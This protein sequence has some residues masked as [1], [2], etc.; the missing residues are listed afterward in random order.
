MIFFPA[1]FRK[2]LGVLALVFF[3]GQAWADPDAATILEAARSNLLGQKAVLNATLRTD[4]TAATPP[5]TTPLQIR[6]D[7]D[8]HYIFDNPP[9]ELI[10]ELDQ[11]SSAISERLGGKTAPVKPARFDEPVRDTA[12]TYED[13]ALKFLYWKNPILR[14]EDTALTRKCW[15]IEIQAPR[16]GQSQYGVARLWIDQESGALM[17]M[18]GYDMQGKLVRKF[19]VRSGQKLD[20][21]WML[22]EMRFERIDPATKKTTGRTYLRVLDKVDQ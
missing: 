18:E 17:K 21:Q 20:G 8:V 4:P 1:R 7:G 3:C 11:D 12:I 19:E 13:L 15:K 14:G 6:V 16:A 9:Q 5:S 2:L 22:K 10:L